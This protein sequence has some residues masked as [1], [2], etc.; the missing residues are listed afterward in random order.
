[1]IANADA[2][3]A[4]AAHGPGGYQ[5]GGR[6]DR[7]RRPVLR[8]EQASRT[9]CSTRSPAS[10]AWPPVRSTFPRL[11]PGS[12]RSR[13]TETFVIDLEDPRTAPASNWPRPTTSS[14]SRFARRHVL[15]GSDQ[16][17]SPRIPRGAAV[18]SC[19]TW[20]IPPSSSPPDGLPGP[21]SAVPDDRHPARPS[22]GGVLLLI[23]H[24]PSTSSTAGSQPTPS[25]AWCGFVQ[26]QAVHAPVHVGPLMR[27]LHHIEVDRGAGRRRSAPAVDYLRSGEAVGI[28]PRPR[29]RA[30]GEGVQDGRRRIAAGRACRSSRSSSGAPSDDD[31]GPPCDFSRG[32]TISIRV[33]EPLFPHRHGPDRRDRPPARGRD[34]PARRHDPGSTPPKQPPGSW[35]LPGLL[36]R[37]RPTLEEA[38]RLDAEEK[39]RRAAVVSISRQSLSHCLDDLSILRG[40]PRP[41]R[42]AR[43][44]RPVRWASRTGCGSMMSTIRWRSSSEAK[45]DGDPTLGATQVDLDPGLETGRRAGR[46]VHQARRHGLAPGHPRRRGVE[47]ADSHDL[48]TT[49]ADALGDDPLRE[50]VPGPRGLRPAAPGRAWPRAP[51]QRPTLNRR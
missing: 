18:I 17:D 30:M 7:A 24:R 23:N 31:K 11:D 3:M 16:P 9:D 19:A 32:K 47:V 33:G 40:G 27:S 38:A 26:A 37:Q 1:M 39:E 10:P 22:T 46:P 45:F 43:S 5:S 49:H 34:R 4:A 28:F 41:D 2:P 15:E 42:M 35:W 14:S 50:T 44:D 12:T 6:A 29:S 51:P 36:R 13:T 48:Q 25:V 21:G 20:R 8:A